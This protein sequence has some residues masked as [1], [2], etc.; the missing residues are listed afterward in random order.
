LRALRLMH[1]NANNVQDRLFVPSIRNTCAS[2]APIL[3]IISRT[4]IGSRKS[5]EPVGLAV[6][7]TVEFKLVIILKTGKTLRLKR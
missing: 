2:H 7:E 1:S 5:A 4:Y 6:Q 3:S